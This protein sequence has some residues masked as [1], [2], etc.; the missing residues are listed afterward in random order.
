[1]KLNKPGQLL[2]VSLAGLFAAAF[3]A[4]CQITTIDYVFVASSAGSG[5]S[6]NG[7]IDVFA[8]DSQSGALRPV[9]G[10]IATG[11]AQPVSMAVTKNYQN[12]YL[13]NQ[14]S[15]NIVHF[16]VDTN[17]NLSLKDVI[18]LSSE[19]TKP[20]AL[21]VNTTGDHL[22]VAL[23]NHPSGG[24]QVA[25][26]VLA[27]FPL[28]SSGAIGTAES[29][30]PIDYWPLVVPGFESD[31]I[32]PTGVVV[33]QNDGGVFVTAFDQSAY[34]P[35]GTTTSTANPGWVFGFAIGSGLNAA[36]G[37]P[38]KAGV[39]P[40]SAAADPTNRFVYVTDFASNELIGFSIQAGYSLNF[41]VNGPFKTGN[42]PQSVAIDPRG[43]F[44]YVANS[45][46]SSVSA[47]A[48]DLATGTP[49]SAVNPTGS[50]TNSTDTQ[51]VSV[52]I[53]PALGRFVYTA[54]KLGN[55]VSGFRLDP[56][57]GTLA[58]AQG[59]P[60]PTGFA[61]TALAS[62]PHGQHSSQTPAQ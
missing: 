29:N 50:A 25:G 46:D 36:S 17:G 14:A 10:S 19:G 3:L 12:L 41:L 38:F 45:L 56:N 52:V 59:T 30:G 51:P 57:T 49:S 33:T 24:G 40:T 35:G 39:K 13:A 43:K 20:V 61:P 22:Y 8:A 31:L 16:A 48:I 28:S 23:A 55:S 11:G 44:I 53:D 5:S 1:M 9:Q 7:V 27:A 26:A 34:N 32:V 62:V 47:Y 37:S 18:K 60:Y 4:A 54:N 21:A 58:A 42:E 2:F 6:S 15:N